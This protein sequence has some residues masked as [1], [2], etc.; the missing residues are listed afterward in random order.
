[1]KIT[2]TVNLCGSVYSTYSSLTAARQD[3]KLA[4]RSGE[5]VIW[6]SIDVPGHGVSSVTVLPGENAGDVKRHLF[7]KR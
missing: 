1:M 6:A 2:Y 4:R 7:E 3:L 5:A